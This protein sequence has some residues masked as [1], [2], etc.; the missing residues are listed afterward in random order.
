MRWLDDITNS[1]DMSLRKL[2]EL[3]ID[4]EAWR[5]AVHWVTKSQNQHSNWTEL[6]QLVMWLFNC[7]VENH[8]YSGLRNCIPPQTV[9]FSNTGLT[10][11][12]HNM[13][14]LLTLLPLFILSPNL[15]LL[16]LFSHLALYMY[17]MDTSK[18]EST[19][20]FW[21]VFLWDPK[22]WHHGC[23]ALCSSCRTYTAGNILGIAEGLLHATLS[24]WNFNT[25]NIHSQ[26]EDSTVDTFYTGSIAV[27]DEYQGAMQTLLETQEIL[28]DKNWLFSPWASTQYMAQFLAHSMA[29]S[30]SF[31]NWVMYMP[32]HIC[33]PQV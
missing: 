26:T 33:H 20:L 10:V 19:L 18:S 1:M 17:S 8:K 11:H 25:K 30:N 31:Q 14:W 23:F 2:W 12:S 7:S 29:K 13:M 6:R 27:V 21:F 32:F 9:E 4:K 15:C 22:G 28:E 5:A 24:Y 16:F 3:V